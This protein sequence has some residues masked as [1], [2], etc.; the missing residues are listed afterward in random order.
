MH[1]GLVP[2]VEASVLID[3]PPE[4]V[5]EV[6][7]DATKAPRWTAGLERM[8]VVSG[9][10]GTAG[11]V[12]R[13]HYIEGGRRYVLNDV[14]DHVTPNRRYVARVSGNGITARVETTLQ[15]IGDRATQLTLQWDGHGT[16]PL[17]RIM[18][19]LMKRRIAAR[20]DADLGALRDLVEANLE[21]E[22]RLDTS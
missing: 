2:I 6:L 15:P 14:L 17:T 10:P 4:T 8:E 13:A 12:G 16:A 18:I 3:A 22:H 20:V 5:A 11:C 19:R 21:P 9:E 1:H 7:L